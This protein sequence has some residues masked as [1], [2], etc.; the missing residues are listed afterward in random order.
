MT[1]TRV[2]ARRPHHHARAER[3]AGRR[4][5][6]LEAAVACIRREGAGASMDQIA[7]EAGVTKPVVY[8]FFRDKGDLYEAIATRYVEAVATELRAAW[9]GAGE[10]RELLR[11]GIDTYLRLVE[12][13]P[14][15][16]RFLMRRA[17]VEQ[18]AATT[19]IDDFIR[20]LGGEL[21]LLV[22]EQL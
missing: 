6:L 21:G 8:R 1:R 9:G 4:E 13:E 2:A 14:E 11:S 15:I 17:R 16:S 19:A 7:A 5:E 3:R 20:R 12:E 18:A 22:G 10:P